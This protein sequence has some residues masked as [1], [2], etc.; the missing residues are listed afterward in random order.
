MYGC[1]LLIVAELS[2]E[3]KRVIPCVV[4]TVHIVQCCISRTESH[5]PSPP[6]HQM[7]IDGVTQSSLCGDSTMLGLSASVMVALL[8]SIQQLS[9][10][11]G[12][13]SEHRERIGGALEDMDAKM[14]AMQVSWLP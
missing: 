3:L 9:N 7:L 1:M 4:C 8:E 6:H 2:W 14:Q 11:T 5:S 12:V 13:T 10:S